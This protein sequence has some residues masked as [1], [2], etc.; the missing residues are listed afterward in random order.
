MDKETMRTSFNAFLKMY[1]NSC[2]EVYQ[3]LDLKELTD[4]QFKY[5]RAIEKN[6]SMTMSELADTFDL[7][8]PTITE[9]VRRFEESGLI[10]KKRC[11]SDGRVTNITLT[12]RGKLLAKT[13]V[14][15][16]DKA[17][18]KIYNRLDDAELN[19][20]KKLFDKIGQV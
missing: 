7:S 14:L 19:L 3:E 10:M 11:S 12:K 6:T 2:R 16:S 9:V 13:N 15:E 1:F 5:L 4:R 17:L 18:E 20:L 8:K